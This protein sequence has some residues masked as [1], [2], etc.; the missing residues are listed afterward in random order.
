VARGPE[1]GHAVRGVLLIDHLPS[2]YRPVC[3]QQLQTGL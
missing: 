2:R 3:L 1:H